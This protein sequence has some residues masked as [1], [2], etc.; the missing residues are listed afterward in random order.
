MTEAPGA[1]A[2]TP[3]LVVAIGGHATRFSLRGQ[4][5]I[6]A[7]AG[8]LALPQVPHRTAHAGTLSALW[9]G[10]DEWL[11]V[12]E[13]PAGAPSA[14]MTISAALDGI[15]CSLVDVSHRQIGINL[16][17]SGVVDALAMV[18]PLDLAAASFPVGM[19][20]RTVFEKAE[21]VLWRR[22]ERQFHLEVARS[23]VPYVTALLA[24]AQRELSAEARAILETG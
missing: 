19:A 16:T 11:L 24:E 6:A 1:S 2:Q 17:G 4:A 10:P 13:A 8:R 14:A 7:L 12:D 3:P 15:S 22:G 20:T 23:F 18:V 9:L 5:A 21:I